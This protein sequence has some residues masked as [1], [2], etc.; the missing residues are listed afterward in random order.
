MKLMTTNSTKIICVHVLVLVFNC[1]RRTNFTI[2]FVN[3]IVFC[4]YISIFHHSFWLFWDIFECIFFVL[5]KTVFG[6][7][8]LRYE[9]ELFFMLNVTILFDIYETYR[10]YLVWVAILN[11]STCGNSYLWEWLQ[12][13][14][15]RKEFFFLSCKWT[16]LISEIIKQF[17]VKEKS[18]C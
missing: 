1:E 4:I 9:F 17:E 2:F 10:K 8:I 18:S 16:L 12:N 15:G 6:I 11:P 14:P 7:V 5:C 3:R 13:N